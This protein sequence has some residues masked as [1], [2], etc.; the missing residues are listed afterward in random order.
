MTFVK[1][2]Y[3]TANGITTSGNCPNTC[4]CY[5]EFGMTGWSGSSSYYACIFRSKWNIS[6]LL[7]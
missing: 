3:P 2:Q 7:N 5:A 1:E 4:S 6:S